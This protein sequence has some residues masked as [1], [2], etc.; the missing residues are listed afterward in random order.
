MVVQRKKDL[1]YKRLRDDIASGHYR[2]GEKL[3]PE[4]ELARQLD[5]S[6]ITLRSAL[7]RLEEE[8]LI[9]RIRG[10][11]TFVVSRPVPEIPKHNLLLM[12][13]GPE[14]STISNTLFNRQLFSGMAEL[15][16]G[17]GDNVTA[18]S[19]S[20]PEDL[21]VRWRAGEF[22][23]IVWDRPDVEDPVLA[24]LAE[25]GVPQV[26]VNRIHPAIPSVCADYI[27]AVSIAVRSL[28]RFGHQRIGLCDFGYNHK[29]LKS[30]AEHFV[31][32]LEQEGI[33]DAK[34]CLMEMMQENDA[35]RE[36]AIRRCMSGEN[37]PTAVL[38]SHT[39]F[40][41]FEKYLVENNIKVP[42]DLS[43]VLWGEED[44]YDRY[45]D[46]PYS[47]LSDARIEVGR[48]AADMIYCLLHGD[49][50]EVKDVKIGSEFILRDGCSFPSRRQT[51]GATK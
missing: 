7:Q 15:C 33:T 20:N 50:P 28:K 5:T 17:C 16:A 23:G 9:Q 13:P 40:Y 8:N 12:F 25:Q 45:T 1:I 36:Q 27:A 18:E 35:R 47:I 41:L 32:L 44:G 42:E 14:K 51:Q 39:Y 2:L 30:R 10:R 21:V 29:I 37:P 46:H 11:G 34:S 6:F 49:T 24:Q 31:K 4:L 38:V 26:T 48:R 19:F 22:S 3:L 43:V